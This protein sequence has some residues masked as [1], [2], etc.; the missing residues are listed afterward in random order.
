MRT[1]LKINYE[2]SV[3]ATTETTPNSQY[4]PFNLKENTY[5]CFFIININI[6]KHLNQLYFFINYHV[7]Q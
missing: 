2:K 3:F 7:Y 6:I 1:N 5:Y 4:Q